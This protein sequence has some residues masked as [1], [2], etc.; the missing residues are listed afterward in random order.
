M[1]SQGKYR[2]DGHLF[3]QGCLR[4]AQ[5]QERS[6]VK[7]KNLQRKVKTR[8][9]GPTES[10]NRAGLFLPQIYYSRMNKL[11]DMK[12]KSNDKRPMARTYFESFQFLISV[13]HG[14]QLDILPLASV[15]YPHFLPVKCPFDTNHIDG[16]SDYG[17]TNPWKMQEH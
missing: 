7:M 3:A 16:D 8:N 5:L 1:K 2:L 10:K 11:R 12:K 13:Y 17:P 15:I 4:K 14:A 6:K 9:L